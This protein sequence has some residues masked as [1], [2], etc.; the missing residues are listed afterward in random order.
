MVERIGWKP[1]YAPYKINPALETLS[2]SILQPLCFWECKTRISRCTVI[3]ACTIYV[4]W[5]VGDCRGIFH[6][7]FL[8]F[9]SRRLQR[10]GHGNYFLE[11]W[12]SWW[13]ELYWLTGEFKNNIKL[14]AAVGLVEWSYKQPSNLLTVVGVKWIWRIERL[15]IELIW[16]WLV[17]LA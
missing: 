14:S 7:F 2:L 1:S 13:I 11:S 8:V 4:P 17:P 12:F 5:F 10:V 3:F 16:N 6:F 9:F 15:E